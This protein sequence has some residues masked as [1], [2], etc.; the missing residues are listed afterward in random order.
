MRDFAATAAWPGPRPWFRGSLL[1]WA[2]TLPLATWFFVGVEALPM[3]CRNTTE[4]RAVS[5]GGRDQACV[6][7][8]VVSLLL[9]V[10]LLGTKLSLLF[11]KFADTHQHLICQ[12]EQ[13][14]TDLMLAAAATECR[15][16]SLTHQHLICQQEQKLTDLVLAA[17]AQRAAGD[18]VV[19]RHAGG[20]VR[21]H[22]RRVGG[23]RTAGGI[24]GQG[25]IPARRR[26]PA[27]AWPAPRLPLHRPH[28]SP[29]RHRHRYGQN[30]RSYVSMDNRT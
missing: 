10:A 5:Q 6:R 29:A 11:F 28:H 15:G 4:V 17:A 3:A 30:T 13:K 20:H 8:C 7:P 12:Q 2:A 1:D 14:L 9:F 22:V 23:G 18:G 16:G 27:S 24:Y 19:H 26:L 21:W 25:D